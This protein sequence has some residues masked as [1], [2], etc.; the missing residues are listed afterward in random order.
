M[1]LH[2]GTSILLGLVPEMVPVAPLNLLLQLM[3]PSLVPPRR[4]KSGIIMA[5]EL[6]V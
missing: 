6:G 5:W 3:K 2:L 1:L 4:L